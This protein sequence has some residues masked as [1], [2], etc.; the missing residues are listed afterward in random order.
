[1][2][3]FSL[4]IQVFE[5]RLEARLMLLIGIDRVCPTK[6][7]LSSDSSLISYSSSG[8]KC[9]F[10]SVCF[11]CFNTTEI[12]HSFWVLCWIMYRSISI[13]V[14]NQRKPYVSLDCPQHFYEFGYESQIGSWCKSPPFGWNESLNHSDFTCISTGE[15]VSWGSPSCSSSHYGMTWHV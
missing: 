9:M 11:I 3:F 14:Q 15:L 10:C 13:N 8:F 1:M 2:L 6:L 7:W 5:Q 4:Q 12:S